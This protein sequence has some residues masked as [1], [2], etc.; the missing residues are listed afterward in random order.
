VGKGGSSSYGVLRQSIGWQVAGRKSL[1]H[2]RIDALQILFGDPFRFKPLRDP[3]P[4][5]PW[6]EPLLAPQQVPVHDRVR[7]DPLLRSLRVF[8]E[9]FA[10]AGGLSSNLW[11]AGLRVGRPMEAYPQKGH[12]R[13]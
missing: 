7:F 1:L 3:I 12:L 13:A 6:L 5:P 10:G 8:R 9:G 11:R 2:F 4:L